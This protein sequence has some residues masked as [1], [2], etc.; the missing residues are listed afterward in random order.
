MWGTSAPGFL[1][2]WVH[3]RFEPG[4][5][6]NG[7]R[8]VTMVTD[9]WGGLQ[10]PPPIGY[11][12]GLTYWDLT[13]MKKCNW[14]RSKPWNPYSS[15]A[16]FSTPDPIFQNFWIPPPVLRTLIYIITYLVP[17]Y[18]LVRM[19]VFMRDYSWVTLSGG[20]RVCGARGQSPI[21]A[22]PPAELAPP[23]PVLVPPPL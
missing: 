21:F 12:P 4:L 17:Q 16:S 11:A 22:P 14:D 13:I 18:L 3:L 2:A 7:K 23:S 1:N 20:A 9:V 5:K 10:P 15:V 8:Y 19:I 6:G